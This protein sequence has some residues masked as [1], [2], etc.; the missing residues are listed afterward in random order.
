MTVQTPYSQSH[1]RRARHILFGDE[2]AADT[3]EDSGPWLVRPIDLAKQLAIGEEAWR[4]MYRHESRWA[5]LPT[6][7]RESTLQK[8]LDD[9]V[10]A[11]VAKEDEIEQLRRL[12]NDLGRAA[13]TA[14]LLLRKDYPAEAASLRTKVASAISHCESGDGK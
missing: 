1:L 14:E 6:S 4:I 10:A 8:A 13:D 7:E 5:N 3:D 2:R 9:E 12:L 11:G